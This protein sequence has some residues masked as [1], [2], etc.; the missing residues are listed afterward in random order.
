MM[1]INAEN[2]FMRNFENIQVGQVFCHKGQVFMKIISVKTPSS[3]S[4]IANAVS[5]GEEPRAIWFY[6][7]DEVIPYTNA[8]LTL[9]F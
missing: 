8:E 4:I 2:S 6:D 9:S 3:G 1:K 7:E 5:L